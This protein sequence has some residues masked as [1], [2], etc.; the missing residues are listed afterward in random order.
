MKRLW[1]NILLVLLTGAFLFGCQ[2]HKA[3]IINPDFEAMDLNAALQAGDYKQKVDNFYVVLDS[4]GSKSETYRGNSKFAIANDFL[5]RMNMAIPDMDLTA[6]MRNF[7]ATRNP[8]AKK[9]QLIYGTTKYTRD[10]FKTALDTVKWGGGESPAELAL[11]ASSEDMSI[12]EGKSA[13][14]FVG[15]GEYF[16][17]NPT[18]AAT[19]LK[20]RY[21]DNLC[22]YTVLVGSEDPA[23]IETMKAISDAGQCGFY[24]SAKYLDSPQALADWIAK[25]FLVAVPKKEV[26]MVVG[27]SDSDGITD[28]VDQCPDTPAGAPVNDRGCW[29]IDNVEFDF[30]KHI[31]KSEFTPTLVEIADVLKRNPSLTVRI[32]GH[33]DNV[34]SEDYNMKLGEKRASAARQ[35]LLDQGI[36]ADR[37]STESFGYSRPA[38]TNATE[39]G[40]ARNRRDEFKWDR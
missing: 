38:A 12:F 14:I 9:T 35:Y 28:D 13:L 26:A 32:D 17:D 19:R 5:N 6:G 4:S 33:T 1:L 21:G 11:D 10:G 31:I 24:Q 30:D 22:V 16:D 18:A 36:A 39:W 23:S 20:E 15:D 34:G 40:R 8:F 2:T 25:V 27:D 29:I 3:G 37:I 7:G